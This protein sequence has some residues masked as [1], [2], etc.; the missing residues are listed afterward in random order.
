LLSSESAFLFIGS[1][2]THDRCNTAW[3]LSSLAIWTSM[4]AL[5]Q[6]AVGSKQLVAMPHHHWNRASLE[7][8]D[9][10]NSIQ[11]AIIL[12]LIALTE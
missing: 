3:A 12:S 2:I 6:Y 7:R 11:F 5:L 4:D 9:N 10:K 1:K 8:H